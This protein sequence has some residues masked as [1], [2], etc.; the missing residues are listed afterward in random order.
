MLT[1][2]VVLMVVLKAVVKVAVAKFGVLDDIG[3]SSSR[4]QACGVSVET[5]C[6]RII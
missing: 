6:V 1:T 5:F 2:M 3:I 4:L